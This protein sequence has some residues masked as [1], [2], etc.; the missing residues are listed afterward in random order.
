MVLE[1]H[2]AAMAAVA[3]VSS[4]LSI[5]TSSLQH[6]AIMGQSEARMGGGGN[7]GSKHQHTTVW[8]DGSFYG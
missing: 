1:Y 4:S 6:A 8:V 2:T 3:Q 7:R 5:S